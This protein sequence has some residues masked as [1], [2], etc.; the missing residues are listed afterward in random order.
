M[1]VLRLF[2]QEKLNNAYCHQIVEVPVSLH[3]KLF[4]KGKVVEL[5]PHGPLIHRMKLR[6]LFLIHEWQAIRSTFTIVIFAEGLPI[7]IWCWKM[8]CEEGLWST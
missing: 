3:L 1:H 4:Y 2:I 5:E 8:R 7:L 6:P